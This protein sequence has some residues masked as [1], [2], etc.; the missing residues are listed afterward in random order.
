MSKTKLDSAPEHLYPLFRAKLLDVLEKTSKATGY[1]WVMAEGY[2]SPER[3]LWLYASGRTRPGPVVTWMRVPRYHGTGLAADCYPTRNGRTPDFS[4]GAKHYQ[5]FRRIYTEAGLT[6]PAWAK[7]DM[8][9]VQMP[10]D[11]VRVKALEWVRAGFPNSGPVP[12]KAPTRDEVSVI[13]AG[14]PIPDADAFL[15]EGRAYVAL[16]P[17]ADQL[18]WTIESVKDGKALLVDDDREQA[19]PL[20]LREGRGFV[21]ARDLEALGASVKWDPTT[22]TVR[23]ETGV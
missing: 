22:K 5:T 8:G 4:I 20:L 12:P 3:Q 23:I 2:R 11:A 18:D 15:S 9:H 19:L 17:V 1:Q 10:G 13:V 21:A 14:H 7:G 16:R 6:N